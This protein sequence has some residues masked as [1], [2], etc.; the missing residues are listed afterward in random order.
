LEATRK[1]IGAEVKKYEPINDILAQ[2]DQ[3]TEKKETAE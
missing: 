2:V 1:E 3:Q